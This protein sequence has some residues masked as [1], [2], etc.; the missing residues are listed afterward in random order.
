MIAEWQK[1]PRNMRLFILKQ[2]L[3]SIHEYVKKD[4]KSLSDHHHHYPHY[5]YH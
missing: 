3:K 2:D 1:D 5:Q 4:L